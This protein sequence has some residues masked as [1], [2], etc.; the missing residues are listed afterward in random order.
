MTDR[1]AAME[2]GVE[3]GCKE[4]NSLR[5]GGEKKV[6]RS[7]AGAGERKGEM[8]EYVRNERYSDELFKA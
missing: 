3:D 6:N 2:E 1:Q 5:F 8:Q 7:R 4:K